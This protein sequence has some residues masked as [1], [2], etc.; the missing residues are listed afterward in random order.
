MRQPSTS[1]PEGL[2]AIDQVR[3]TAHQKPIRR[4][5]AIAYGFLNVPFKANFQPQPLSS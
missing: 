1:I 5:P 4:A 2:A 3:P